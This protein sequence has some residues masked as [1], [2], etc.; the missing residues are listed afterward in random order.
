V[1]SG[2]GILLVALIALAALIVA[3]EARRRA[4][5]A[6]KEIARLH[7]TLDVL[8]RRLS[9]LIE[10]PR[11]AAPPPPPPAPQPAVVAT[12][13]PPPA[14]PPAVVA[15]PPPPPAP[16]PPAPARVVATPPTPP[17]PP[18]R[19]TPAPA[20]APAR[21]PFDWEA[22]IGVKLFSWIGGIALVLA[23]IF[24]LS[25]SV[26][27]GWIKPWLRASVGLATGTVLIAVCEMRMA[28]GYKLTA[29][30]LDGAGIAILYATL[31]ASHALW[32]L[33]SAAVIFGA[34]LVVTAVAVALSIRRDSVFIALLGLLGGFATPALL[35][36]GENKPIALFTY[37]LL[38][39]I[40]LAWVA[41]TK[42]WPV[43]TV[44]TIVLTI[45]YEWLWLA[46]FLT[47]SQLPLAATIFATFGLAAAAT[48]FF[49]RR[50][51]PSQPRFD[52]AAVAGATMPFLFAV[53]GAAVPAYGAR[54]TVLFTF[55]LLVTAALSVIAAFRPPRW[56][57]LAGG[58]MTV[59]VLAIWAAVSYVTNAWPA[60]V[61]WMAV[62]AI[63]Q[64]AA[65]HFSETPR[66]SLAPGVLLMF[67]ILA[68]IEPRSASP[69]L[70]F[71]TLFVL[72]ALVAAYALWHRAG[73][74]YFAA[75]L[76]ALAA[77]GVWSAKYLEPPRLVSA[78]ILYAIFA[79][80]FVGVPVVARRLGRELEPAVATPVV[81]LLSIAL[82]FTLTLGPTAKL[83][84]WGMAV[85]LA[86]ANAGVAVEARAKSNPVV[87]A[88]GALLSWVV[89]GSWLMN[90]LSAVNVVGALTVAAAFGLL[91]IGGTVWASSGGTPRGDDFARSLF[92]T[93]FAYVFLV[94]IAAQP[95][96]SI[97][98][99][100]IFAVLLV[101]DLA[102]GAA[103]IYLKRGGLMTAALVASQIVLG[104]W[105]AEVTGMPWP[106]VAFA[107]ALAVGAIGLIWLRIDGR[108]VPGALSALF[109]GHVVAMI[110]GA[111]PLTALGATHVLLL[112]AIL[113]ATPLQDVGVLAVVVTTF[114]TALAPAHTPAEQFFFA[115]PFYL[116]FAA[117]PFVLGARA[118][119][120]PYIA[121]VLA[122]GAF[123]VFARRAMLAA[124]LGYAI[125]ILPV[126]EA[127]VMMLLVWRLLR[128]EAKG[129]RDLTRLAVVAGTALAFITVA[130]PLQLE[131]QWITIGWALEAAA[132]IWLFRRIPH[133]G[134]LAWAGALLGAVFV[135]L[136]FNPEV[137]TYHPVSHTPIV[138]WYL[139]TY[140]VAAAAFFAA[141]KLLPE[142]E[143]TRLRYARP[144]LGS[145][146]T[147]L[148]FY[149]VNIEIAD[150]YSAG[151]ALTFNFFSSS[152]AQDLTYTIG[153]A[154]FAVAMLVAGIVMHSRGTRLAAIVLLLVTIFKCFLHDL[155]RLG[156]LYRVGSLLGLTIS[157]V[158]VAVLLQ[159][160]VTRPAPA[161]EPP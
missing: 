36:T 85:L 96:L 26:Q 103:A 23:A 146:G 161:E 50:D 2:C 63:V 44:L 76:L 138:N 87:I 159:R 113:V 99:W 21:K 33:A 40:G 73:V 24:F 110:A 71:G 88:V 136:A 148:L 56:L 121:A 34:M 150:F 157:V 54:Y 118:K 38:L 57:H 81:L 67:P 66:V 47:V 82:L 130:I 52:V 102:I 43:L 15:T 132:L 114:A 155:G 17:P 92:L 31:F 29:D 83:A 10:P 101:L 89:I 156:G 22:L 140:V 11:P 78:L 141:A 124:D 98:P 72:L 112:V 61:A 86:I 154:L 109:L 53:F 122:S 8:S 104:A 5:A 4:A 45:A 147:V 65:S 69:W 13:P 129:A 131:K 93:L 64:L 91:S 20:P 62:F 14:P 41:M 30:A 120:G 19:P 149:V 133:R 123:F 68:W 117:W 152:L 105:A 97:P 35:S 127:A 108:F 74:V 143:A 37:L 79:I 145:C 7:V 151:K 27:H 1:A 137:F 32:H 70:L 107:A 60:V 49:A 111:A 125:G 48:L 142:S 77:E 16:P 46:K 158:L 84:L 90:S 126:A 160:F 116:I 18:P 153:W 115:L 95:A 39:N 58:A 144:V 139:Y 42:R 135:R 25:Y 100:P 75:A 119:R 12:P 28:R 9:D 55:L 134:L 106:L 6:N 3:F 80:F 128:I 94:F 51:D 59:I